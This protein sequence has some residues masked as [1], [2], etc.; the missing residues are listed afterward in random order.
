LGLLRKCVRKP[1]GVGQRVPYWVKTHSGGSA[2]GGGRCDMVRY[3][4]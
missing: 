3:G 1:S 2:I 4:T